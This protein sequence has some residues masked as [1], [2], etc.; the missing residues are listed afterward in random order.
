MIRK[1]LLITS[2]L[3]LEIKKIII[4]I[5]LTSSTSC[6][7]LAYCT[8]HQSLREKMDKFDT[9]TDSHV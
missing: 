8:N 3:S 6:L 4:I 7:L 1:L 2:K 5:N 9:K